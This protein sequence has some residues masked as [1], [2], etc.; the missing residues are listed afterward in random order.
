MK[1]TKF[2]YHQ[3]TLAAA[4]LCMAAT[5][6]SNNDNLYDSLPKEIGD[7]V[8]Q[9]F[10]GYGIENYSHSGSTYHVRLKNGPGLTFGADQRW[11]AI[12]GY[13]MPLPQVLVYNELPPA[14]FSYL[15]ETENTENV[16]AMERDG[17]T[18]TT[19]LLDQTLY[20]DIA[21]DVITSSNAVQ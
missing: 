10:S 19:V 20:Y 21:T 2:A 11:E 3:L 16:F 12:N 7:F 18:Y 1:H 5:A 6:C 15:Q 4:I 13:G 17:F 9:Y 14:L 8:S